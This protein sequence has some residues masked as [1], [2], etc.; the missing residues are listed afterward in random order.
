MGVKRT[1]KSEVH[2]F[3]DKNGNTTVEIVSPTKISE[4]KSTWGQ[5]VDSVLK[6]ENPS[7]LANRLRR[8]LTIP[9]EELKSYAAILEAVNTSASNYEDACILFRAAKN[10]ELRYSLEAAERLGVMRSDA[11]SELM[12]EYKLKERRSPTAD[13]IM[14]RIMAN[15]PDEYKRIVQKQ[16]ALHASVRILENL[17]KA[18]FSRCNDLRTMADLIARRGKQWD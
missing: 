12:S 17:A 1:R 3:N 4:P 11:Q 2:S 8:E 16:N 7:L 15:W 18:W 6:V 13:D 9:K 10:E 5:L 14:D